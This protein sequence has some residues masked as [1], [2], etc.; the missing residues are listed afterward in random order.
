MPRAGFCKSHML[1]NLAMVRW[2]FCGHCACCA[3]G[4]GD[5]WEGDAD[6]SSDD[7]VASSVA[8]L[9]SSFVPRSVDAGRLSSVVRYKMETTGSRPPPQLAEA[10]RPPDLA[11]PILLLQSACSVPRAARRRGVFLQGV[12]PA[13]SHRPIAVAERPARQRPQAAR[14]ATGRLA[15]NASSRWRRVARAQRRR[16]AQAG[17]RTGGRD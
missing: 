15:P 7:Y 5:G 10:V 13:L 3:P 8:G 11:R 16:A 14:P 1:T 12:H 2:A 17:G 9:S 4:I 6:L